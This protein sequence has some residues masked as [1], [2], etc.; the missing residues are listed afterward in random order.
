MSHNGEN[1]SSTTEQSQEQTNV[2]GGPT[3]L[4]QKTIDSCVQIVQKYRAGK[5]PKAQATIQ[6][7]EAF[8]AEIEE[9]LLFDCYG[10]YLAMLDNFDKFR[11]AAL[12]RGEAHNANPDGNVLD[13]GTTEEDDRR[14]QRNGDESRAESPQAIF[15]KQTKRRRDG[16]SES[17]DEEEGYKRQTRLDYDSLPWNQKGEDVIAGELSPSLQKTR[18]LLANFARD[19]K[20]AK[21]SLLNCG[22]SYPQFPESEW[23]NLLAGKS[24]DLDHVLSG[25][26]SIAHDDSESQSVT[27]GLEL[28]RG[29]AK[30]ARAV[31]THGEWVMAYNAYREA[32]TFV[33][34][35]RDQELRN[36]GNHIMRYFASTPTEFHDRVINYDRAVRIRVAQRRDL[37][38]TSHEGFADLQL[39][40]INNPTALTVGRS[41]GTRG[42]SKSG[43]RR[44]PCRRWNDH[45]CPNSASACSYAHICP[46]CR[47]NAH[48]GGECLGAQKK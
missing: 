40:W 23:A 25:M 19:L 2:P 29:P 24:V 47:S 16:D 4:E 30:P 36:Y 38:L 14:A 18:S 28:L 5:I 22:R 34:E 11:G 15:V 27:K 43:G 6:L 46:N 41:S 21:A 44:D 7:Y 37:E 32:A 10:S 45:R 33:F 35:H 12:Q 17:S 20:R 42:K 9:T 39:Q 31:Q 3:E 1:T 48:T 13:T 26:Y 8:P